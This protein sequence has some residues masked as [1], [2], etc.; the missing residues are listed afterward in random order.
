MSITNYGQ[1]AASM[2]AWLDRT[3]DDDMTPYIPEFVDLCNT[4]LKADL[5]DRL[6]VKRSA[7]AAM[8]VNDL[9]ADYSAVGDEGMVTLMTADDVVSSQLRYATEK[10]MANM[11]DAMASVSVPSYYT[12][13]GKQIEFYPPAVDSDWLWRMTYQARPVLDS[14]VDASTND[15]LT[16]WPAL[17]L[18]GSLVHSAPFLEDD[19]RL[20][21][22]QALYNDA[23]QAA[24]AHAEEAQAGTIQISQPELY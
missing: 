21:T 5:D 22:W 10:Q 3:A 4:R 15:I 14:A 11:G 23:L 8:T 19:S 24:N 13:I 16:E 17:Y 7:S 12:I 9:P 20:M 2:K 18:Y 6:M 1:L